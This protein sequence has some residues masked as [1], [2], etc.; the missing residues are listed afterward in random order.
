VIYIPINRYNGVA[1]LL[2]ILAWAL[3]H[4]AGFPSGHPV[5][6]IFFLACFA[7]FIRGTLPWAVRGVANSL[8]GLSDRR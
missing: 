2:G 3:V 4:F 6:G 5:I 8:R 7:F 1:A